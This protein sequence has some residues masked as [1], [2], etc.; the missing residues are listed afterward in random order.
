MNA[1]ENGL[2]YLRSRQFPYYKKVS[3]SPLMAEDYKTDVIVNAYLTGSVLYW[4]TAAAS[5]AMWTRRE[6]HRPQPVLPSHWRSDDVRIAV[7]AQL[8]K[9]E[10]YFQRL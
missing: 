8:H 5:K 7:E 10:P 3:G 9:I 1:N 2:G 4:T 6:T